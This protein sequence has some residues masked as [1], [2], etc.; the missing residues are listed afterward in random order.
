MDNPPYILSLKN[1]LIAIN[2]FTSRDL[3]CHFHKEN[4]NFE[5]QQNYFKQKEYNSKTKKLY[6]GVEIKFYGL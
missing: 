1:L 3:I 2:R 4:N 6:L 5:F